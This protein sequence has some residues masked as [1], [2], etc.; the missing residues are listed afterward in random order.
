MEG[1][2]SLLD[3]SNF[4]FAATS[5][6]TCLSGEEDCRRLLKMAEGNCRYSAVSRDK[7]MVDLRDKRV[8]G[9]GMKIN[10]ERPRF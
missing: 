8:Y 1:K 10:G 6:W 9:N 4:D 5:S 3:R 7:T 2:K